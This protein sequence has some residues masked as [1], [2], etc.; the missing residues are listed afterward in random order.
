MKKF[1]YGFFACFV[2]FS[3]SFGLYLGNLL[4]IAKPGFYVSKDPVKFSIEQESEIQEALIKL[5]D[6]SNL[7]GQEKYSAL[8]LGSAGVVAAHSGVSTIESKYLLSKAVTLAKSYGDRTGDIHPFMESRFTFA[9]YLKDIGEIESAKQVVV[10]TLAFANS[11]DPQN[12]WIG[13][14]ERLSLKVRH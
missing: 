12:Y 3:V 2:V 14:F 9:L 13:N 6:L 5:S 11:K 1:I 4:M 7:F 10:D 8:F